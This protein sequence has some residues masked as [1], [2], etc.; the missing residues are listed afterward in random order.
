MA[1]SEHREE[2]LAQRKGGIGGTDISAIVGKNPW[3]TPLDVWLGKLG[4]AQR[5]PPTEAMW[6]GTNMEPVIA[7][8]YAE[9]TGFELLRGPQ[10]AEFWKA[11]PCHLWHGQTLIEH[12][13]IPVVIGTPD[14][15]VLN[16]P[17]GL[18]V[19]LSAWKGKEWG[20]AGT[21]EVP[22][23]YWLQCAWYVAITGAEAWDVAVCFGGT[24]MEVF[25][26][27][28]DPEVE[29]VLLDAGAEFWEK[30]VLR[31]EPPPIDHSQTWARYLAK[32]F[33]VGSQVVIESTPEIEKWARDL[34]EAQERRDRAELE[35]REAKN[36]L[37]ALIGENKGAKGAFGRATWVRP[38][39]AAVVDWEAVAIEL[40]ATEELVAKYSSEQSKSAY[41]KV[42]FAG[43][44][45]EK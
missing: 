35:E 39:P 3:K 1:I 29:R 45:E 19:K 24:R 27:R 40:G 22:D 8:R 13:K 4:L 10:I 37:M 34:A 25:T 9:V 36:N 2:W 7:Q 44:R 26:V 21:D 43:K 6:F 38:R 15:L 41:L 11:S 23:H 12:P 14:A 32:K 31:R 28:R 5:E 16:A 30:Y 20:R 42:T 33:A 17:R 18:E